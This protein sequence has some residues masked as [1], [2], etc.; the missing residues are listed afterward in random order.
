VSKTKLN[1]PSRTYAGVVK[2]VIRVFK[3][4]RVVFR[5]HVDRVSVKVF[6]PEDQ[7]EQILKL[8]KV[9]YVVIY[10]GTISE[11]NFDVLKTLRNNQTKE[12]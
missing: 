2:E 3:T 8:R 10:R 5:D 1:K 9:V 12:K 4:E 7:T 6:K 11:I